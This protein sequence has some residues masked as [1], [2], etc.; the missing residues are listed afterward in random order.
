MTVHSNDRPSWLTKLERIGELSGKDKPILFN[1]LGH[2]LNS[3]MLKEQFRRLDGNKAI[4]IDKISKEAYGEKLDENIKAL[5][6]KLRRRTYRPKPARITEIPKEDGSTRPLAISCLEDKLVQ[7]SVST[8]LNKIYEPLFLA[9]SYGYRPGKNCHTALKALSQATYRNPKGAIV[10]IDIRKYFNSIPHGV[11]MKLLR[12]KITDNRFLRLIEV[13]ITAPILEGEQEVKNS[14]GCPAGSILSPILANVYLHYLI[15]EWFTAIAETHIRGQAELIRFADDM[16]FVFEKQS[17]AQRFYEVLPKRLARG[18][19][20]MHADKSQVI[21]AGRIAAK[22]ASEEGAR[23]PTFNF[24]GFTCYWGMARKGFW[25]LKYTS[26]KD[27]FAAKLRG[28]RE[29]L[30]ENLNVKDTNEVIRTVIRV[31]RGWVNYHGVSDNKR[32][33]GQFLERTKRILLQWLNRRGGKRRVTWKKL[34]QVLQA[35]GFPKYWKT[36]S[37]F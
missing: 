10:E 6:K 30:W 16:V 25:R 1:N 14:R 15:D 5:I 8:I 37:M 7:L 22:Q 19:L 33:I 29:Y 17:E 31:V 20:E 21:P 13:L 18:G 12:N 4:G 11:I 23:L 26:R 34:L 36:V 2:L 28:L 24:L 32:R 9:C 3:D 27:R 35:E